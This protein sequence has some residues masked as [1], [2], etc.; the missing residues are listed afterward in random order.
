MM[1][2]QR[3]RQPREILSRAAIDD[4]EVL[5]QPGG[6]VRGCSRAANDNELNAALSER[7]D[8][9]G[10]VGHGQ[11]RGLQRSALRRTAEAVAGW[12]SVR[13]C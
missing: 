1:R 7:P 6:T 11:P 8:E 10:K 13:R 4:V 5:R 12:R 9:R 2:G 3:D